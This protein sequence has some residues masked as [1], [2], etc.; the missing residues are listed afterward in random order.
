MVGNQTL[1]HL[2]IMKDLKADFRRALNEVAQEKAK[3]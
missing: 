2:S 1:S 3:L